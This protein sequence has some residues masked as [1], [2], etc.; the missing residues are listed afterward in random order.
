VNHDLNRR[1][2]FVATTAIGMLGSSAGLQVGA[3][4]RSEASSLYLRSRNSLSVFATTPSR[5]G[6]LKTP[7]PR[8]WTA[9]ALRLQGPRKRAR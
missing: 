9:L 4:V 5:P 8:S 6:R 1:E 7:G 3:Q 2:F